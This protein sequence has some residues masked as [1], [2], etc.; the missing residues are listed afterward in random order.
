LKCFAE[1]NITTLQA[2][3]L[4]TTLLRLGSDYSEVTDVNT[5]INLQNNIQLI[6]L[7]ELAPTS[8]YHTYVLSIY[9]RELKRLLE[10]CLPLLSDITHL[11]HFSTIQTWSEYQDIANND[12]MSSNIT[13][14]PDLPVHNTFHNMLREITT[15]TSSYR[16]IAGQLYPDCKIIL[17][18][19]RWITNTNRITSH[20]VSY[21]VRSCA[22]R[23]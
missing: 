3:A 17:Q 6:C 20:P 14:K 9:F 16:T 22:L 10:L 8:L 18:F 23:R 11:W 4:L 2:R 13:R 21:N 12:T 1:N 5:K 7:I 15:M 19:H